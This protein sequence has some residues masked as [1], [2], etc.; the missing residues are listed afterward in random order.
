[1]DSPFAVMLQRDGTALETLV[2]D[3][4][5]LH[6]IEPDLNSIAVAANAEGVPLAVLEGVLGHCV[7]PLRFF[8]ALWP[9]PTR[10]DGID[11]PFDTAP[12]KH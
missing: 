10:S 9:D 6:A 2:A 1:M 7:E 8:C 12:G 11:L 5:G 3:V 4:G